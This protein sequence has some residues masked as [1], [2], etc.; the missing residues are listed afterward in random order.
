MNLNGSISLY[1]GEQNVE[2]EG[3]PIRTSVT[4]TKRIVKVGTQFCVQSD[5]VDKN[6]GCWPSKEQA[7]AV[8]AGK[9][10]IEPLMKAAQWKH[11]SEHKK[12]GDITHASYIDSRWSIDH[13]TGDVF[14]PRDPRVEKERKFHR[15]KIEKANKTFVGGVVEAAGIGFSGPPVSRGVK[16]G[17]MLKEKKTKVGVKKVGHQLTSPSMNKG[18]GRNHRLPN[19][20]FGLKSYAD[21]GEPMAGALQ[22]AHLD[23]NLWFH[24][25]SLKNPDRIPTDDPKEK[26]DRFGDVTKRNQAHKDRMKLLKRSA[27]G[28]NP[29]L[30]PVRT[31]LLSPHQA[32]YMPGMMSSWQ[33]RRR[34]RAGGGMF[35]A[36]G[37]AQI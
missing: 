29:P 28:G 30:I 12:Y 3:G 26:N 1:A 10:F 2:R 23:T 34:R 18:V 37:A 8:M 5:G 17:H 31:T 9:S 6:L 25:P 14:P 21:M 22:H 7:E 24:P 20:S 19:P 35:R 32:A 27:P 11:P 15:K 16:I 13:E 4:G 36:F 33:A